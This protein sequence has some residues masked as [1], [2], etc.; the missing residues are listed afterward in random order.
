MQFSS[1]TR[2]RRVNKNRSGWADTKIK[3]QRGCEQNLSL[4]YACYVWVGVSVVRWK[5]YTKEYLSKA[6]LFKKFLSV[7][8]NMIFQRIGVCGI[9]VNYTD[10]LYKKV[11]AMGNFL[12][13]LPLEFSYK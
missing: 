6:F 9:G 7:S 5:I 4:E 11:L 3:R 12:F 2:S 10:Y 1:G 8:C 13:L